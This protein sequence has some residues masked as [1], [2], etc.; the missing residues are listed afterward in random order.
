MEHVKE[1]PDELH[2]LAQDVL[3]RVTHFFRDP[4]AF[5]VLSRRVFPALIRKTPPEGAVR[6]WA[7]GCSTG[8]EAYSIAICFLE[9][10]AQMQSR[11]P[12]QVFATDI[13]EAAIEKARRG[14][15]IE[16][17]TGDVSPERL[18]RFFVRA[19]SGFQVSRRLRDLCIFSRHDLLNDPPF[20]RM[21]LV[22][23]RNVL[24]YL[25]S[26]RGRIIEV[27]FR[28]QS[29]R[30]SAVGK[31]GNGGFHARV[32]RPA[33]QASKAL[34]R[35]ESAR[36]PVPTHTSRKKTATPIRRRRRLHR[37]RGRRAGLILAVRPTGLWLRGTALH[38]R[39]STAISRPLRT[40]GRPPLS[41]RPLPTFRTRHS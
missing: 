22:S 33:G 14:R 35:Q 1:N 26:M 7:S 16:N 27:P 11:V 18:A 38:G 34:P 30:L 2:A 21:G 12:L 37:G 6:V 41:W 28:S 32:V 29:R 4:E 25:D 5:E 13:N 10:A 40:V 39:S 3:I 31:V 23:C 15:Y 19:G 36:H 20:S 17:I 24:I 8:E 9:V